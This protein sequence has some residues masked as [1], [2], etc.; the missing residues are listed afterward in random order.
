MVTSE[1]GGISYDI[2][3]DFKA[4][5]TVKNVKAGLAAF[6]ASEADFIIAIGGGKHLQ[7]HE[8]YQI[9]LQEDVP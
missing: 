6:K 5:P 9:L 3:S 2:F 8:E 7:R 1:L 4:N